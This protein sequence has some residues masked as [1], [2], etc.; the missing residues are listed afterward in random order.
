MLGLQYSWKSPEFHEEIPRDDL[1]KNITEIPEFFAIQKALSISSKNTSEL[2][3]SYD[4]AVVHKKKILGKPSNPD[5]ALEM[6]K[7][8]NGACHQV[9]TGVA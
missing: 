3:I 1:I 9:I 6:L 8:L 5:E 2:V 7:L 4:T